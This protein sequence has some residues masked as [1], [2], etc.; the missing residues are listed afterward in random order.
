MADLLGAMIG[1][2]L[3]AVLFLPVPIIIWMI[4]KSM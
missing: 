1:G 3:M 4:F 2:G